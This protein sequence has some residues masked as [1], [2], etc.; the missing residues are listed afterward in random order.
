[1]LLLLMSYAIGVQAQKV[2]INTT[3]PKMQLEINAPDSASLLLQNQ[4]ATATNVKTGIYFNTANRSVAGIAAVS[5]SH[6]DGKLS[7]YT[8]STP[9]VSGLRERLTINDAGNVG[10]NTPEPTATLDVNGSFRLRND[11]GAGAL[12]TSDANGNA[13]WQQPATPG[14]SFNALLAADVNLF[15]GAT[16]VIPFRTNTGGTA[17]DDADDFDNTTNGYI[18][19]AD[20]VYHFDVSADIYFSNV[21]NP[22]T[23][24][25]SC[26]NVLPAGTIYE[27]KKRIA[28]GTAFTETITA[29]FTARLVKNQRI[30][31]VLFQASG[32]N[33]AKISSCAFCTRFMGYR[34]Y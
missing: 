24:S 16:V 7:F 26:R 3:A 15:N 33:A 8:Y 23:L 10:I 1:M 4:Q 19:P 28:A 27:V 18:A 22:F 25:L 14:S 5:T 11:A 2:G 21:T 13:S 17:Y 30:S 9:A 6:L 20:G 34:L 29:S 32:D 12:L 31:M